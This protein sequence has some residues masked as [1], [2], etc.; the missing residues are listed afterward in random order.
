MKVYVRQNKAATPFIVSGIS[1]EAVVN[2]VVFGVGRVLGSGAGLTLGHAG[3]RSGL[4]F[5]CLAGARIMTRTWLRA[6]ARRGEVASYSAGRKGGP[7]HAAS[8]GRACA[9]GRGWP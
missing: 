7:A 4:A 2:S 6:P 8:A 3:A 9:G 5:K 1:T